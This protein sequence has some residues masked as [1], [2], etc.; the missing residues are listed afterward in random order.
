[1]AMMALD[2]VKG[3]KELNKFDFVFLIRLRYAD[4]ESS[5][6]EL[7]ISQHNRLEAM[8][9]EPEK[10]TAILKG[11][12]KNKTLLILDGY[13]EY[14]PGTNKDIDAAIKNTLGTSVLILTSRPGFVDQTLRDQMKNIA[15]IKGFSEENIQKTSELLLGGKEKADAM[16]KQ[17]EEVGLSGLLHV[18]II[19]LF[20]CIIFKEDGKLPKTQTELYTQ[21]FRVLIDRNI[22]K[23]E[24]LEQESVQQLLE[25]LGEFSWKALQKETGQLL[26]SKVINLKLA[27]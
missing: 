4:K 12:T 3:K 19:L 21:I 22:V 20:S 17:A 25:A 6:A 13:D 10:I 15:T 18:P 9:I 7:I 5:L 23:D 14:K 8:D 11:K 27:D 16:L 26:L 24:P 1:M 2:W